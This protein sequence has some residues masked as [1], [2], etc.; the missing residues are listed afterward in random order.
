MFLRS[1]TLRTVVETTRQAE[2]VSAEPRAPSP[3]SGF[4]LIEVVMV[5]LILGILAV[6]AVPAVLNRSEEAKARTIYT[7]AL[8]I[9]RAASQYYANCGKWP[10]SGYWGGTQLFDPYIHRKAFH[11]SQVETSWQ[12]GWVWLAPWGTVKALLY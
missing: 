4:T 2:R 5:V 3:R 8:A 7:Q 9:E 12:Y 6:I 10:Y 1:N 11:P